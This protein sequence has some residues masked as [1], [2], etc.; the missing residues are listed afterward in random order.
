MEKV[1][2]IYFKKLKCLENIKIEF[3]KPLT[4]IMG[5]NGCG[6]T[7]VIHA[8]ACVY[9]PKT[10]G[11]NYRFPNFFIPNT[12]GTWKNS[13]FSVIYRNEKDVVSSKSYQKNEDRWAP[14]YNDRPKRDVF[15][16]GIDTCLPEIERTS[17]L[18]PISY[19]SS[20]Q[21]DKISKRIIEDAAFILNKEYN[22]LFLNNTTKN[23][24]LL[25]VSTN[26]GLKY[27]SLSMGTGEQRTIK[28]LQQVYNAPAGSL[29]LIDELDLLLHASALKRLVYK[30]NDC[31]KKHKLQI[32]FTTHSI[33]ME[34]LEKE[35]GIQYISSEKNQDAKRF[36]VYDK[37]NYD[38]IYNLTNKTSIKPIH[39]YVEDELSKTIVRSIIR[40]LKI[41]NK[42]EIMIFG[43]ANNAYVVASSLAITNSSID[44]HLIVLDGDVDKTEEEKT[45]KLKKVLSGTE[46]DADDKRG[47]AL[48]VIS[49]YNLP[50]GISPEKFIHNLLI[51]TNEKNEIVYT[52]KQIH[53]V[54]DSH[55]WLNMIVEQLG[56]DSSYI[57]NR[58]IEIA[59]KTDDWE[60]YISDVKN[61]LIA[62][63][64]L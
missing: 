21:E 8:L 52:A 27:S 48:N 14:R 25:G 6:K 41:T 43:S 4:A 57:L 40:Q 16:L 35:V 34:E 62:R 22:A 26:V 13:Y 61:W 24:K 64:D 30:L 58:I 38:I 59:S 7:T 19:T 5:A 3:E 50:E 53:A 47:K 23:K 44:D 11:E 46:D 9:Q 18:A 1:C 28:I 51:N 60:K 20:A 32:V 10:C 54:S 56:D 2:S 33:I 12:D 17:S 45:I 42:C 63:K 49:Q 55:Q 37:I 29:I 36:L 15:Y 31:A 39:I